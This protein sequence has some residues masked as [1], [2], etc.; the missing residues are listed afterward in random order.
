[1]KLRRKR[2]NAAIYQ[3]V[4]AAPELRSDERY[5]VVK[6]ALWDISARF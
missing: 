4:Q 1:M 6:N 3:Q 5:T 2:T